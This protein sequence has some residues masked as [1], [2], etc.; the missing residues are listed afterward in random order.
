MAVEV[1]ATFTGSSSA[2][3]TAAVAVS[4]FKAGDLC[5]VVVYYYDDFNAK[6]ILAPTDG[7]NTYTVRGQTPWVNP[8]YF[9]NVGIA[10][11]V[12]VTPPSTVTAN[13][14]FATADT[15]LRV[16]VLRVTGG[17]TVYYSSIF[18]QQTVTSPVV[19]PILT[20]APAL[21]VTGLCHVAAVVALTPEATWT[22]GPEDEA[23][24]YSS[25]YRVFTSPQAA[26][27]H[28]WTTG[29]VVN[30]STVLA[31]YHVPELVGQTPSLMF[32]R[33]AA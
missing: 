11:T 27:S 33:G 2:S 19:G 1:A 16:V 23:F 7:S 14:D 26:L 15:A 8:S 10:D 21:V 9:M 29:G 22:A 12:V 25:A 31:S 6:Q 20:Q 32:G 28:T 13:L 5:V 18:Q 17:T 24:S 4:G 3:P 30:A